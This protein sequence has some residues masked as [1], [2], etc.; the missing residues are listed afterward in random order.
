MKY[1][2]KLFV[3]Q[4]KDGDNIFYLGSLHLEGL[5]MSIGDKETI[6]IYELQTTKAVEAKVEFSK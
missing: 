2:K 1:P 5:N 4:E 3:I 6:G